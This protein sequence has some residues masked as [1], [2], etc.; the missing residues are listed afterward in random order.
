V[1]VTLLSGAADA[2]SLPAL[3]ARF[4]GG[5]FALPAGPATLEACVRDAAALLADRAEAVARLFVAARRH[6][7][8]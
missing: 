4:D 7:S 3:H 5:C 1:P 2:A 8:G 6:S